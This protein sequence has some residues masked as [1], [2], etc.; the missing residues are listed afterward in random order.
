VFALPY[1]ISGVLYRGTSIG[2]PLLQK[3]Q[4]A[5]DDNKSAG[6]KYKQNE[7]ATNSAP[8]R[9]Q[10]VLVG[11]SGCRAFGESRAG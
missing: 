10:V 9:A 5:A 7:G 6:I 11:G 4:S 8:I 3:R 1:F 2:P